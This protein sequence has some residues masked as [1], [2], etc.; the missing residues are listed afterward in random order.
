MFTGALFLTLFQK[1]FSWIGYVGWALLF[2]FFLKRTD[3][4]VYSFFFF[5]S[6]FHASGLFSNPFFSVKHLH[7]ALFLAVLAGWRRD[8]PF[9]VLASGARHNRILWFVYG[10]WFLAMLAG[11]FPPSLHAIKISFNWMFV[12]GFAVY[13]IGFL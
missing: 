5:S 6:F 12:L 11:L 1:S 7:I 13:L 8:P 4:V 10:T 3:Y 2:V 9:K